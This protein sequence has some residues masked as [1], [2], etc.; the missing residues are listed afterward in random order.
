MSDR[1]EIEKSAENEVKHF[2]KAL[3]EVPG[4]VDLVPI[5]E[6]RKKEAEA[7][8]D[9][10]KNVPEGFI[11]EH[12]PTLRYIQLTDEQ[13]L[14]GF[15]HAFTK[16]SRDIKLAI[17]SSTGTSSA[18]QEMAYMASVF[19][20]CSSSEG[21]KPVINQ[22]N[23][24]ANDKSRKSE[25]PKRLDEL[26]MGL[27]EMFVI[28]QQSYIKAK[29]RTINVNLGATD[30]RNVLQQIWGGLVDCSPIRDPDKWHEI[31]RKQF[32]KQSHRKI[33]SE[34]LTSNDLD[35][36]KLELLLKNMYQLYSDLS[37]TEFGKNI[38]SKDIAKL[39]EIYNRWIFQIDDLVNLVDFS[40]FK[41]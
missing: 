8:R 28:A 16:A 17:G 18:F 4:L 31:K 34:C 10:A 33:V 25:I 11:E 35:K 38:L 3:N 22:F 30:L 36:D 24:L 13:Q 23:Q 6:E 14:E 12:F 37:V 21:M 2:D 9:F 39:D 1:E 41:E 5:F 19:E 20:P 40:S 26:Y 27:G 7:K 32:K 15:T 29:N